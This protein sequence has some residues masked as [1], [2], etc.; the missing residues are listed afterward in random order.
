METHTNKYHPEKQNIQ[1]N[2][3][4]QLLT[5][6][7]PIGLFQ[8]FKDK[9]RQNSAMELETC[10]VIMGRLMGEENEN[11]TYVVC[12]IVVPE[13]IVSSDHTE[14]TQVGNESLINFMVANQCQSV[15]LYHTHPMYDTLPSSVD[16][17][18]QYS[19]HNMFKEYISVIQSVR[20]NNTDIWQLSE[21]G[22]DQMKTCQKTSF[23]VDHEDKNTG[24]INKK[25][26]HKASHVVYSQRHNASVKIIGAQYTKHTE[27]NGQISFKKTK[28]NVD[29]RN[30]FL[31]MPPPVSTF[32]SGLLSKR[33]NTQLL[34]S[35]PAVSYQVGRGE[36]SLESLESGNFGAAG[37]E[38]IENQEVLQTE[39]GEERGITRTLSEVL[40]PNDKD[41]TKRQ[42]SLIGWYV[43]TVCMLASQSAGLSV[44]SAKLPGYLV[45]CHY[46]VLNNFYF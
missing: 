21:D 28:V 3:S 39:H 43:Y 33:T 25:L 4:K 1:Q 16:L 9:V 27:A 7:I 15:G 17:H 8:S 35:R 24:R 12:N 20:D 44:S 22:M 36:I 40:T 37:A 6:T 10:G 45:V 19:H 31:E 29:Q 30:D 11:R 26:F 23:H 46:D 42:V 5:I 41:N 18:N 14:V 34:L 2:L 13:Q 38:A 32:N